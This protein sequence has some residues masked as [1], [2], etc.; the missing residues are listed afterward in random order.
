[1]TNSITKIHK[2]F[3]VGTFLGFWLGFIF[4]GGML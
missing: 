2:T 3:L 4:R 1:M